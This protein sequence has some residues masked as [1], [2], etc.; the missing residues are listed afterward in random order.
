MSY[1]A[2]FLANL[3]ALPRSLSTQFVTYLTAF[4]AWMGADYAPLPEGGRQMMRSLVEGWMQYA[5]QHMGIS[6]ALG[7]AVFVFLRAM[8]QGGITK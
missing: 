6:L 5:S 2:D 3:K 7:L 1:W 8:P 4:W